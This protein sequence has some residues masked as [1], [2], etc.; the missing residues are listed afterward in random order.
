MIDAKTLAAEAAS[1]FGLSLKDDPTAW[2]DVLDLGD[3][4]PAQ[5]RERCQ[6]AARENVVSAL[7]N[8]LGRQ[9][10]RIAT[11]MDVA[12]AEDGAL[13][14]LPG[15]WA[16]QVDGLTISLAEVEPAPDWEARVKALGSSIIAAINEVEV[17]PV[18]VRQLLEYLNSDNRFAGMGALKKG[19]AALPE[20]GGEEFRPPKFVAE[21]MGVDTSTWDAEPAELPANTWDDEPEPAKPARRKREPGKRGVAPLAPSRVSN[22]PALLHSAGVT[23]ADIARMSGFSDSYIGYIFA[24]RKPWPGLRPDQ[25]RAMREELA[26]RHAA[27]GEALDL[28]GDDSPLLLPAEA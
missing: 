14:D 16:A 9:V 25:V 6:A 21:T 19:V 7:A 18:T 28:L 12:I 22:F 10:E 26:V 3:L 15:L 8:A 11:E 5:V 2:D 1:Q 4:T 24:G 20:P 23:K 13:A 17:A 27:L